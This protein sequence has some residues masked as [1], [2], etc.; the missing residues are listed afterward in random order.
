MR[1]PLIATPVLLLSVFVS[2]AL[3]AWPN[4][5]TTN[6]PVCT[7]FRSQQTPA[8]VSDGAGGAV[9]TWHD[10]R[11]GD[12][13]IYAQHVLASGAVDPAWPPDG[14]VLCR[15]VGDQDPPRIVSDGAGAPSSRGSSDRNPR[16]TV[17][18]VDAGEVAQ[19][20]AVSGA[21]GGGRTRTRLPE[22]DS[23]FWKQEKP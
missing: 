19:A 20:A 21:G 18:G 6:L 22:R 17:A 15:A 14:Q 4:D 3:G 5:P 11:S 2:P 10:F 9:I 8:I 13:D 1:A 23:E 7:A 16:L 12:S